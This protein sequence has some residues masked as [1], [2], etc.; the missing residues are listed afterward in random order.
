MEPAIVQVRPQYLIP[1]GH[2]DNPPSSVHWHRRF[3]KR[4]HTI[5]KRDSMIDG[6]FRRFSEMAIASV[7]GNRLAQA[8]LSREKT[9]LREKAPQPIAESSGGAAVHGEKSSSYEIC[10]NV[11]SDAQCSPEGSRTG[12]FKAQI[13][14]SEAVE[15]DS[16]DNSQQGHEDQARNFQ[17]AATLSHA[18]FVRLRSSVH[19]SV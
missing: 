4:A 2:K 15:A 12:S 1:S 6:M 18:E 13:E 5:N 3:S 14:H 11:Y 9:P 10:A 16:V 7:F 8:S 19:S 17:L